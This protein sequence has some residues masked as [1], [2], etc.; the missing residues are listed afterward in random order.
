MNHPRNRVLGVCA[1]LAS[2][3]LNAPTPAHAADSSRG[4][5][6]LLDN[7]AT[8][9]G[10]KDTFLPVEQAFRVS[11]EALAPDQVRVTW[12]IAPGYY[13][14]QKRLKF[15]LADGQPATLGRTADGQLM[16]PA[17][18]LFHLVAG[19]RSQVKDARRR[20]IDY[21]VDSFHELVYI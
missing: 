20:L 12:V 14:Y 7:K 8:S 2:L 9:G 4:V 21:L 15:T 13:L 19:L 6:A 11:A 5:G 10:A 17:I 3:W 18:A 1:L 16:V